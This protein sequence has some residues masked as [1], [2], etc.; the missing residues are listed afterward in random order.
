MAPLSIL[1]LSVVMTGCFTNP[2][3]YARESAEAICENNIECGEKFEDFSTED[4]GECV[5]EVEFN[6]QRCIDE[7]QYFKSAA[8][9]CVKELRAGARRC[10]M[11]QKN[12]AP[13]NEVFLCDD[14]DLEFECGLSMPVDDNSI[15]CA[16]NPRT[17]T[18]GGLGLALGLVLLGLGP[19]RRRFVGD[20]VPRQ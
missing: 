11:D 12:L 20:A 17:G 10:N 3:K 1:A 18:R 4:Y 7:C 6:R 13:C 19:I 2:D 16:V 14:E 5:S 8:R 9:Q 15:L